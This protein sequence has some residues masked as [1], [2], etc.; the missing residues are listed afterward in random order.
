MLDM[1]QA[2]YLKRLL[3]LGLLPDEVPE[4]DR[5]ELIEIVQ[6]RDPVSGT[7]VWSGQP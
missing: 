3:L 7:V 2:Q 1:P 6:V 5:A 4:L